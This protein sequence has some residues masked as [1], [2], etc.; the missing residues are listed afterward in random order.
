MDLNQLNKELDTERNDLLNEAKTQDLKPVE[1][2]VVEET[3]EQPAVKVK[4]DLT[5]VTESKVV[6]EDNKPEPVSEDPLSRPKITEDKSQARLE[7]T[8]PAVNKQKEDNAKA[9]VQIQKERAEIETLRKGAYDQALKEVEAKYSEENPFMVMLEPKDLDTQA[10][11]LDKQAQA[12]RENGEYEQAKQM[13][14]QANELRKTARQFESKSVIR[15]NHKKAME[16]Y[17]QD[18][19]LHKAKVRQDVYTEYPELNDPNSP[20]TKKC[21]EIVKDK[22]LAEFFQNSPNGDWY[23]IQLANLQLQAESASGLQSE[24]NKLKEENKKLNKQLTPSDSFSSEHKGKDL[25]NLSLED[26][27][28]ALRAQLL[29]G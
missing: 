25:N 14:M 20:I 27:G 1:E 13:D 16:K 6:T 29:T 12:L 23:H 28:K 24:L 3:D 5:P 10:D 9:L 2:Q 22:G 17:K 26:E 8:W 11:N 4:E 21:G 19:E 18:V 7:K 15:E